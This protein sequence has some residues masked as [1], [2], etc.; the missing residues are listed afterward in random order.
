MEATLKSKN[1]KKTAKQAKSVKSDKSNQRGAKDLFDVEKSVLLYCKSKAIEEMEKDF[2]Y[3]S[4]EESVFNSFQHDLKKM[5]HQ[6]RKR[7]AL[8]TESSANRKIFKDVL[9]RFTEKSQ[10]YE[11]MVHFSSLVEK[12]D[13]SSITEVKNLVSEEVVDQKERRRFIRKEMQEFNSEKL[14]FNSQDALN[15]NLFGRLIE[16]I[17]MANS[18]LNIIYQ[19]QIDKSK[20]DQKSLEKMTPA[21]QKEFKTKHK[22]SDKPHVED[23]PKFIEMQLNK[24]GSILSKAK[25]VCIKLDKVFVVIPYTFSKIELR[26]RNILTN[27]RDLL[28]S[29]SH[30]LNFYLINQRFHD[31]LKNQ[32][33]QFVRLQH[34]LEYEAKFKRDKQRGKPN[35]CQ[36]NSSGHLNH[37]HVAFGSNNYTTNFSSNMPPPL[38]GSIAQ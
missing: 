6:I 27:H 31:G 1:N 13:E 33:M 10:T 38:S 21:E 12:T 16:L 37:P 18:L 15:N 24:S 22:I 19:D 26:M 35:L 23:H 20:R 2:E 30:F 36:V 7:F 9:R 28:D 29:I 32:Y 5:P 4:D 17:T 3:K 11:F 25:M 8:N 34:D 14:F